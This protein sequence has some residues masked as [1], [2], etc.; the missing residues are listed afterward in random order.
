M[1]EK[2]YDLGHGFMR[3]VGLVLSEGML[4][5]VGERCQKSISREREEKKL[6]DMY[7]NYFLIVNLLHNSLESI[8]F[9]SRNYKTLIYE[10]TITFFSG[11]AFRCWSDG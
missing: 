3:E 6:C 1:I 11:R 9:A 7:L 2:Y 5:G 8:I 4:R 10:E